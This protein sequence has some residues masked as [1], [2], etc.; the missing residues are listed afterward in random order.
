MK[1]KFQHSFYLL[2]E[3]SGLK[4]RNCLV[5]FINWYL[6]ILN[7]AKK[8]KKYWRT[9]RTFGI[10]GWSSQSAWIAPRVRPFL[11][12]NGTSVSIIPIITA[13]TVIAQD[14]L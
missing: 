10:P 8:K 11:E 9:F 12:H 3:L 6:I 13:M 5:F 2:K 7:S 4:V 14:A 1:N